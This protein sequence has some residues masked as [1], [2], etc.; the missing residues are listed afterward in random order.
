MEEVVLAYNKL[1]VGNISSVF[2]QIES[3][4][5]RDSR[6][7]TDVII[8]ILAETE[9]ESNLLA[10]SSM[11]KLI[12]SVLD[13]KIVE[14]VISKV[15]NLNLYCY[16]FN[17]GLVDDA[18]V[19]SKV[20]DLISCKDSLSILKI[21]QMCSTLL[22]ESTLGIIDTKMEDDGSI[23]CKFIKESIKMI[24][25]GQSPYRNYLQD[26]MNSIK[27]TIAGILSKYAET[28]T[29]VI[30][31]ATDA[32][33]V[34]AVKFGMNTSLK[35]KIFAILTNS[36]DYIEAQRALYKQIIR[37][38]WHIEEI[39]KISIGLC[40]AEKRYNTYYSSLITSLYDTSSANHKSTVMKYIYQTI[41]EKVET[42]SKLNIKEI[43]N[44]GMLMGTFYSVGINTLR[45]VVNLGL[46]IKKEEV[47]VRV[48]IKNIL[49]LHLQKKIKKF[50]KMKE[51]SA[52]K[53]FYANSIIDGSFLKTEN[54][55]DLDA[56]YREMF[57]QI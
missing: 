57:I 50:R 21:L 55:E 1:T 39:V 12:H 11:L 3:S 42:L 37:K 35:K 36:Q 9:I 51:A 18:F 29:S 41:D 54:R 56:L 45:P 33:E 31:T 25:R 6:E 48:L 17:Y 47:L 46:I 22:D 52:F 43:Y 5:R 49:N 7:T 2:K 40:I 13:K 30:T 27:N 10:V 44:L 8:K 19:N 26:E 15:P 38:V 34:I 4:Y 24:R 53:S 14:E 23:L 28:N 20:S 32:E 16:I